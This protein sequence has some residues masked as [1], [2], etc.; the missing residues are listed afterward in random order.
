MATLS[1]TR[2]NRVIREFYRRLVVSGK[3]KKVAP[4][5]LACMRKLLSI[6]AAILRNRT[7]WQPWVLPSSSS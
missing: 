2:H 6:L 3:P 5:K 4:A 1:A 7:P